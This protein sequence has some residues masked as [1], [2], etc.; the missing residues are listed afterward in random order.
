MSEKI[1]K[2]CDVC[3]GEYPS[4][5][6][7][8]KRKWKMDGGDFIIN[9]TFNRRGERQLLVLEICRICAAKCLETREEGI[10]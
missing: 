3:G 7:L 5:T 6:N 9:A 10:S 1:I 8:V 4:E 2:V